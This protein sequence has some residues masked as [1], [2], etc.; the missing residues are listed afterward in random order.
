[1]LEVKLECIETTQFSFYKRSPMVIKK[2]EIVEAI[3]SELGVKFLIE[4][5]WTLHY[6]MTD[7]QKTFKVFG[8]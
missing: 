3:I 8:Q 2:G 1:M 7:I 5:E 4:K 6:R